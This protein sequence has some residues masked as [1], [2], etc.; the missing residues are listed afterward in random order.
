M[1]ALV[2]ALVLLATHTAAATPALAAA[3]G[4]A[5]KERV[6]VMDLEASG[7]DPQ[8]VKLINDLV[9]ESMSRFARFDVIS[10]AD[11]RQLVTV[12]ANK[13]AAGCDTSSCLAEVAGALG[14]RW[15]VFGSIGRLGDLTVL[16]VSL[17]DTSAAKAGGRQRIEVHELEALPRSIDESLA[18]LIGESRPATLSS[19]SSGPSPLFVGGL[20]AAGVGA[21]VAIGTGAWALALDDSL[22]KAATAAGDKQAAFD[23][24]PWAIGAAATAGVVALT[25][26]GIAAAS[27]VME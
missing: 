21:A 4:P 8:Q 15:V 22:G 14:A 7:V 6:L 23:Y 17:F 1:R 5:E 12:E 18:L 26:A 19:Q 16:T 20:V 27:M 11:V 2:A 24:G 13:A 3:P 9:T 10:S 25:G